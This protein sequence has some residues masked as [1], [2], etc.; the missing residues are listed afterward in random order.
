M[1]ADLEIAALENRLADLKAKQSRDIFKCPNCKNGIYKQTKEERMANM[2]CPAGHIW[3]CNTCHHTP[4]MEQQR[5]LDEA[6][7]SS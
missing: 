6:S 1:N 4:F 5:K 3:R 2:I 7:K